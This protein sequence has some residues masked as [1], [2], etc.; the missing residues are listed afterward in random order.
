MCLLRYAG[1]FDDEMLAYVFG[2]GDWRGERL[3]EAV[4]DE[5]S[6]SLF[7]A[8]ELLI[9]LPT[10]STRGSVRSSMAQGKFCSDVYSAVTFFF[11]EEPTKEMI[12]A[13]LKRSQKF[14]QGDWRGEQFRHISAGNGMEILGYR[15]YSYEV[16]LCC[17]EEYRL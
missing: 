4:E 9:S 11:S 1:N 16:V 7:E 10:D 12:T 15:L 6:E 13:I 8:G 2:K 17:E 3:A 5:L 14:A